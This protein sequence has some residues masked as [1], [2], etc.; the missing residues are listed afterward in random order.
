MKKLLFTLFITLASLNVFADDTIS[1]R[2]PGELD[3][4]I[5]NYYSDTSKYYWVIDTITYNDTLDIKEYFTYQGSSEYIYYVIDYKT[6]IYYEIYSISD[7]ELVY[8]CNHNIYYTVVTTPK[9]YCD[10][11]PQSN[12]PIKIYENGQIFIK[13]NDNRLYLVNGQLLR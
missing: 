11:P 9:Y 4:Y 10:M 6:K 3:K 7:N 8:Y 5:H 12:K 13:L 1:Y 2:G